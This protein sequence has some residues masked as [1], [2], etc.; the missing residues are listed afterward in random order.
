WLLTAFC[1]V[2]LAGCAG[3]SGSSGFDLAAENAAIDQA[4]DSGGCGTEH[5]LTICAPIQTRPPPAVPAGPT[6]TARFDH[7]PAADGTPTA[8]TTIAFR[9]ATPTPTTTQPSAQPVVDVQPDPTDV[10]NCGASADSQA[11]DLRL[12]FVPRAAPV[13]SAYRAAVRERD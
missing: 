10:A 9:T 11:C 13:G 2:V 8:T 3:G 5:G 7:T 6:P 12:T 4:L 1:A